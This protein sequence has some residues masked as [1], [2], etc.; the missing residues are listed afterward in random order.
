M[1]ST[2]R[3]RPAASCQGTAT[4]GA[5]RGRGRR[6]TAPAQHPRRAAVAP[7]LRR[8]EE[9]A[10]R[11]MRVAA[12]PCALTWVRMPPRRIHR[13][14]A[15]PPYPVRLVAGSAE[16]DGRRSAHRPGCLIW[17]HPRR[18]RGGGRGTT[19]GTV[20]ALADWVTGGLAREAAARLLGDDDGGGARPAGDRGVMGSQGRDGIGGEEVSRQ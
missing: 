13:G 4:V 18:G 16:G 9:G 8:E 12:V 7:P 6:T 3:D 15:P 20:D 17:I 5:R 2:G 19:S 1:G 10:W 14:R 11:R